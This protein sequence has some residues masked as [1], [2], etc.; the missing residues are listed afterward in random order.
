MALVALGKFGGDE[1]RAGIGHHLLVETPLQ[2][3]GKRLAA[4]DIAHFKDRGA[5]GHVRLGELD[6]LRHAAGRMPDLLAHVPEHVEDIFDRLQR[7]GPIGFLD[8]EQKVDIGTRRQRIASVAADGGDREFLAGIRENRAG[9]QIMQRDQH[10][11]L[12]PGDA[13]RAFQPAAIGFEQFIGTG[14]AGGVDLLQ[15]RQDRLARRIRIAVILAR[16]RTQLVAQ[17]RRLEHL[18]HGIGIGLWRRGLHGV[19][20]RTLALLCPFCLHGPAFSSAVLAP[21]QVS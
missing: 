12:E 4:G 13:P 9:H 6:A 18:R 11:V 16:D 8:Q 10:L 20:R 3:V 17:R 21:P 15:P 1:I 7:I 19:L 2:R 14:A 5:D